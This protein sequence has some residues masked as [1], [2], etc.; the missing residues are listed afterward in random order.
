ML[1]NKHLRRVLYVVL[2]VGLFL[3][4]LPEILRFAG[5][6]GLKEFAAQEATIEDI[7]LNLFTGRVAVEGMALQYADQPTL[8]LGRLGVD[9][10]MSALFSK[11]ILIEQ[12]ELLDLDLKV[13]EDNG[14]WVVALPIPAGEEEQTESKPDQAEETEPWVFGLQVARLNNVNL[15]VNFQNQTHQLRLDE[16]LT[17][18]LYMW[19]PDEPANLA[20]KGQFNQ[21]PLDFNANAKPFS[22]SRTFEFELVLD[23]LDLMPVKPFLPEMIEQLAATL[24]IDTKVAVTL[25][26]GGSITLEQIGMVDLGL[27][28]LQAQQATVST[29]ALIWDGSSKVKLASGEQPVIETDGKVTVKQLKAQHE[30]LEVAADLAELTWQGN[31]KVDLQ[32]GEDPVIETRS[33]IGLKQ[34][35]AQHKSLALATDL[36][37]LTWQG[38]TFIDL[39]KIDESLKV[40]GDLALLQFSLNDQEQQGQLARFEEFSVKGI[41]LAG[42]QQ[43]TSSDI[44][45]LDVRAMQQGLAQAGDQAA[46]PETA[47][48]GTAGLVNLGRLALSELELLE[49][50][51]LTVAKV[52]FADLNGDLTRKENGEFDVLDSWLASVMT[53]V[54]AFQA[55]Q[56]QDQA[57]SPATETA[58]QTPDVGEDAPGGESEAAEKPEATEPFTFVVGQ[59]VAEGENRFSL[60]D[61]SVS[62]AIVHPVKLDGLQVGNVDSKNPE[63]PTPLDIKLSLYEYGHLKVSGKAT[64]LQPLEKMNADI[65]ADIKGIELPELSAYIEPA[66]GYRANSGQLNVDSKAK[67]KQGKLESETEVRILKV[68]LQPVNEE[69]IAK[70]SKKLTMPVNTALSVITDSNDTLKLAIPV[71]GD[72]A[73]PEVHLDKVIRGAVVQAVQNASLTYF[74]YAVQPFGAIMLVSETVGDMALQA[75]F[76]DVEFVPGTAQL[77]PEQ[78]G[79][80]E[81]IAG[82]I[83]EKK[84]FSIVA[85]VVVTEQDFQARQPPLVLPEGQSYQWDEAG[86]ELAKART[87]TIK[88]ALIK[89]F[90]LSPDR[91]QTCQPQLGKGLP[92]AIMG[93]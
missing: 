69:V 86:K 92:R 90:G 10:D 14:Q 24:S 62:P 8:S 33:K 54:E 25:A 70:M 50:K 21:A 27:Q 80:L 2:A 89:D 61:Q 31:A 1:K 44:A 79:Y 76:K 9:L 74:K 87:N 19:Q 49:Q 13:Y 64:P 73:N 30:P 4:V 45:L 7:D 55:A 52:S 41:Q 53:R 37:A 84:D 66:T 18:Q 16:L 5:Q 83:K 77:V 72:L 39:G 34:F 40:A 82:M 91:V 78:A 56:E 85:C 26:P 88:S 71:N 67:I 63:N 75:K 68:D 6:Y 3:W 11:R 60:T 22:E 17:E 57:A 43:I 46:E 48:P 36:A 42:L 20:L 58:A 51:N 28:S 38:D 59:L 15:S 81:K 23:Q 35:K 93:I 29:E 32:S 12:V 47:E 65:V